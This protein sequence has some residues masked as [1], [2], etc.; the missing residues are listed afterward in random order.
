MGIYGGFH[1]S[2]LKEMRY[3]S[4]AFVN[5]KLGMH[6]VNDQRR[7]YIVFQRQCENTTV[8]EL[9]FSG[10]IELNLVPNNESYTCEIYDVSMFFENDKIYWSDSY[11]FE[12]MRENYKGTWLCAEKVRWRKV[13]G[14]I[15]ENNIYIML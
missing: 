2:C 7:L 6:P 4:G 15:G 10:L 11:E 1:D 13:D 8:V 9:E 5:E 14:Y 12:S 3:I